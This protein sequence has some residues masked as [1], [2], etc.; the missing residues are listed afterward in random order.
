MCTKLSILLSE[1]ILY[2]TCCGTHA[3]GEAVGDNVFV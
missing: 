3:S 2:P 1:L